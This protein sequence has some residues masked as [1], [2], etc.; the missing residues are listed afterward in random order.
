VV[1]FSF[2]HA[3]GRFDSLE[4]VNLLD[5]CKGRRTLVVVLRS[6]KN[7]IRFSYSN[8][9]NEYE[10][11]NESQTAREMDVS[12]MRTAGLARPREFFMLPEY[13]S[14]V[15][16]PLDAFY[17]PKLRESRVLKVTGPMIFIW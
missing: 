14:S 9:D 13:S 10:E 17:S 7:E 12:C 4:L 1:R 6:V 15:V 2:Q 5:R 8:E 3:F 11:K 16:S